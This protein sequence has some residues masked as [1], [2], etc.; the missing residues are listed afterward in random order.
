VTGS[1]EERVAHNE[2]VMRDINERIDA[3]TWPGPDG[4]LV[5]FCCECALLGCNLLV[6]LPRDDY[7]Y[8]RENPRRFLLAPGHEL[9]AVEVVVRREPDYVVVEKIGEAGREAAAE[10]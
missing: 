2:S 10:A 7:L 9:P 3:G 5:A 1:F 6:E 4:E 8:V